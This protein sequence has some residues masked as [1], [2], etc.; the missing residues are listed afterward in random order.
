MA[1]WQRQFFDHIRDFDAVCQPES[2]LSALE[3]DLTELP[4]D[5][6]DELALPRGSTFADQATP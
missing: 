1:D 5:I 3:S 6:A 2:M 4:L